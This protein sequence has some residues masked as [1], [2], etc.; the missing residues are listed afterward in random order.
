MLTCISVVKD[1]LLALTTHLPPTHFQYNYV[2][3][4]LH[5]CICI[6]TCNM[7]IDVCKLYMCTLVYTYMLKTYGCITDPPQI[8]PMIIM[9]CREMDITNESFVVQWD[10][11]NDVFPVTYTV[12][13]FKGDNLI[14]EDSVDGLSY[15]VTGLTANTSYNVTVVAVNTCCGAGPVSNTIFVTT[16][17]KPPTFLTT[18][19]TVTIITITRAATITATPTL[20]NVTC[21]WITVV[22]K[23]FVRIYFVVNYF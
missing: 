15:T 11:V 16:N 10:A 6:R 21:D 22:W 1:F 7:C 8:A 4:Y 18:A 9:L 2:H 5:M 12:R 13:W 20:G 14:D 19:T 3:M 17:N 23:I